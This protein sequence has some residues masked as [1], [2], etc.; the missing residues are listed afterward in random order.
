MRQILAATLVLVCSGALYA[1]DRDER[2]VT[3]EAVAVRS[4][5]LE[6]TL[7]VTGVEARTEAV[8]QLRREA[9]LLELAKQEGVDF[10]DEYVRDRVQDM[11][12]MA[13]TAGEAAF[14]EAATAWGIASVEAFMADPRV[15]SMYRRGFLIGEMRLRVVERLE[16]SPTFD[17]GSDESVDRYLSVA[18]HG[19]SVRVP[20]MEI[21]VRE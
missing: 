19:V 11:R 18:L 2:V 9:L 3:N 1:A 8:A 7:G 14:E 16:T 10:S 15:L 6:R 17:G 5:V 12:T 21:R 13:E 20:D 4:A